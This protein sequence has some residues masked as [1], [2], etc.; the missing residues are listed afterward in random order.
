MPS[1][2]T[3]QAVVEAALALVDAE[4]V[5]AL[6]MRRLAD[7]LGVSPMA[8]YAHFENK[9]ALLEALVQELLAEVEIPPEDLDGWE[10]RIRHVVESVRAVMRD[11]P[12]V[13]GLFARFPPSEPGSLAVVEACLDAFRAAGFDAATSAHGFRLLAAYTYGYFQ[14]EASGFFASLGPRGQEKPEEARSLSRLFPHLAAIAPH[15]STWEND[16]EFD[17]GLSYILAGLRTQHELGELRTVQSQ[18]AAIVQSS[19]DAIIGKTSEGIITI[20]NPAAERLYGYSEA[21]A[22]GRSIRLIIPPHRAG[23]EQRILE[24]IAAGRHVDHY[25]TERLRK[26]GSMVRVSLS[27]SPIQNG[28]GQIVGAS[29][30]A[31]PV[32]QKA[33]SP[34]DATEAH[35]S[36]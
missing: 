12:K 16:R 2:L 6:S 7:S 29:A 19:N 24:T 11:H 14:L 28:G 27:V 5:G 1:R 9:E 33:E 35:R 32:T 10:Q 31:R 4:G 23:E 26:D 18:L 34:A 15:L 30:I 17:I 25:E 3:R 20:W 22:V 13:S 21:E 8:P 36:G